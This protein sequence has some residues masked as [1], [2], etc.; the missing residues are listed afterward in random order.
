MND[1]VIIAA[2]DVETTGRNPAADQIIELSILRTLSTDG[3]ED[4]DA[5][6]RYVQRF[7][8]MVPVS[9]GAQ[10][11]HGISDLDLAGEPSFAEHADQIESMLEEADILMG[12]NVSFD[13]R[14]LECEFERLN[15]KL[16]LSGKMVVDP[17]RIWH[18][19]E[20]RRL[21]NAYERF[22]G[23]SL[24][25]AH[26]ADADTEAV[27]HVFRGMKESFGLK[28]S[29]WTDL[30]EM[31]APHRAAWIGGSHHFR[32]EAGYIVFGFGK[33]EGRP[34][35]DVAALDEDYLVWIQEKADFPRHVKNLC[36]GAC[37][38]IP[39]EEFRKKV[40]AHFGE[41]EASGA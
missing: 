33:Y 20:P 34:L 7:R 39:R 35:F 32:W 24:E 19:M 18:S 3:I 21:E 31:T 22:V 15:R 6:D 41:P 2:F 11:V 10:A 40:A 9:P 4:L 12:Y 16:D 28:D 1:S 13:I 27:L 37:S 29:D 26:S 36:K 23:G 14:F 8:P 17:L 30:A 5:A 38:G 25:A